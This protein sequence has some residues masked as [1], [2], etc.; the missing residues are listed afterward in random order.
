MPD[1]ET[2]FDF[3]D[4]L[5]KVSPN[6]SSG[7]TS[8]L[9][10]CE[11]KSSNSVWLK[12]REMDFGAD[13]QHLSNWLNQ[14]L[15]VEPPSD[16]IKAL[17]FGLYN[18]VKN[19]KTS[20]KLYVSGSVTQ[21]DKPDWAV[22][23]EKSY[24]PERRYADSTVLPEIYAILTENDMQYDWEYILCLGYACLAVK[25]ICDPFVFEQKELAIAVG[26]DEG[27]Y[28]FVKGRV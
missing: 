4:N 9:D 18:P 14:I 23:N 26:F 6:V 21:P 28:I 22:W 5:V 3:I 8:L 2:A 11:S 1:L 7:M 16:E 24:L 19:G 13:V 10:Y 15:T 27:D 25:T 20:C 17:W 12:I